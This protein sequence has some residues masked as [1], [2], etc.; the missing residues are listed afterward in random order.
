MGM[1]RIMVPFYSNTPDDLHCFQAALRSILKYFLPQK[2]FSWSKL[3]RLTGMNKDYWTW[4]GQALI[5]LHKMGFAI[6]DI[7][8][9]DIQKFVKR[10]G[11]YLIEKYGKEVGEE[12]IKHGDLEKERRIYN[13]YLKLNLHRKRI[14]HLSDIKRLSRQGYLVV[15]LVNSASLNGQKGYIGHFVVITGYDDKNI[16]FHDPGLPPR[17]NRRVT[18]KK[19]L[20]A[21]AYPSEASQNLTAFKY[22]N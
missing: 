3:D 9:F 7:D 13:K 10:G 18:Y 12:Q 5:S 17:E 8:D 11:R 19:F 4:P 21:W 14:P 16:H 22:S 15:C 2:E 1:F 6:V 20:N